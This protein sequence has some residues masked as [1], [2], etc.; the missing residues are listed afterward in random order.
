[1]F[2]LVFQ[3]RPTK[4]LKLNSL[5]MIHEDQADSGHA[6]LVDQYR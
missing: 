5:E 6:V 1:M 3:A 4:A 2:I